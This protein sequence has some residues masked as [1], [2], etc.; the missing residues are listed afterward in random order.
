MYCKTVVKDLLLK[1]GVKNFKLYFPSAYKS[2][3][4]LEITGDT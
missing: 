4:M 3:L 1:W 2:I